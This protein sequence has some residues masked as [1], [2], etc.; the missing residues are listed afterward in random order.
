RIGALA[1]L[2]DGMDA[3]SAIPQIEF[4][5]GDGATALVFRHLE[6]LGE[7]DRSA[8]AAFAQEHDFAVY[9]QPGGLDTVVPLWPENPR[10]SFRLAPWDVELDFQPLDFVQVNAAL[11]ES[12]IAHALELLDVQPGERVPDRLSGRGHLRLQDTSSRRPTACSS[13]RQARRRNSA[14]G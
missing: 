6:P 7:R 2:V 3:R 9:L 5:A 1:A 14:H 11:N 13:A 8:L 12:M 10:L 4:A